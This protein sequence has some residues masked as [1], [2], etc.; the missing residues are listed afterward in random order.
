VS[1]HR[2]SL[3]NPNR[4]FPRTCCSR[5]V[6][7]GSCPAAS[8]EPVPWPMSATRCANWPPLW[9]CEDRPVAS[10]RKVSECRS[11]S[12]THI[13][14]S[15]FLFRSNN[16]YD[17]VT[18]LDDVFGLMGV[19]DTSATRVV[20]DATAGRP[21]ATV[22]D[23]TVECFVYGVCPLHGRQPDSSLCST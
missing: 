2:E 23:P 12:T 1:A 13:L 22:F 17:K 5:T 16:D 20:S 21:S 15:L 7:H 18:F 19:R 6:C 4:A 3:A 14:T 10:R 8:N 9:I 11:R